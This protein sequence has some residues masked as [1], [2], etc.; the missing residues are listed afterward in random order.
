MTEWKTITNS[1]GVL[2]IVRKGSIIETIVNTIL[3][4]FIKGLIILGSLFIK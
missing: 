1:A 2:E 3:Y 4:E